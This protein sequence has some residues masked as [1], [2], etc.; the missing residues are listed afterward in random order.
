MRCDVLLHISWCCGTGI[1]CRHRHALSIGSMNRSSTQS[2]SHAFTHSLNQPLIHSLSLA[3]THSPIQDDSSDDEE[4]VAL[5][6]V[7]KDKSPPKKTNKVFKRHSPR[8]E[9]MSVED[10]AS[11]GWVDAQCVHS[12]TPPEHPPKHT[13]PY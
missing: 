6:S 13:H 3:L 4:S 12:P 10:K 11:D 7:T 9:E 8:L 2:T 5:A 1:T